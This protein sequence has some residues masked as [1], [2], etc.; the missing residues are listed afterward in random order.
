MF[1]E[2]QPDTLLIIGARIDQ[3]SHSDEASLFDWLDKEERFRLADLRFACHRREF[4]LAHGL[5]RWT[6]ARCL[7]RHPAD[8]HILYEPY[9]K[10]YL[11][12]ADKL[13]FSLAH[14][15]DGV[16]CAIAYADR[17]GVDIEAIQ[18]T[19]PVGELAPDYC[20]R[21]ERESLSALVPELVEPTFLRW[22]TVKESYMKADGRGL[23][24]H[25]AAIC[26]AQPA[27]GDSFPLGLADDLYASRPAVS[28]QGAV[29]SAWNSHWLAWTVFAGQSPFQ[30]VYLQWFGGNRILS[31]RI[32]DEWRFSRVSGMRDKDCVSKRQPG[33]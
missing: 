24:I 7:D 14:T 33:N 16:V 3:I 6:L 27:G 15:T 28:C 5:A 11:P 9:G 2:L 21:L 17:V 18:R 25:P 23:G 30:S 31:L 22:W 4:L 10:P 13:A 29:G 1:K 12:R 20:T 26:C 32:H 19:T 8:V